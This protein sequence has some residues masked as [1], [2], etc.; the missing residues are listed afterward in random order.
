MKN[1]IWFLL[2]TLV[3]TSLA[4]SVTLPF[5]LTNGNIGETETLEISETYDGNDTVRLTIEM[6]AGDIDIVGGAAGIVEGTVRYNVDEWK[7]E[8]VWDGNRLNITQDLNTLPIQPNMN[9]ENKWDLRLGSQPLQLTLLAGAYDG[10]L[11][12]S[13]IPIAS[14]EIRDGASNAEVNFNSP[15]PI[16]MEEFSYNTGASDVEISGLA[17]ANTASFTFEGGAGAAVLDFSGELQGNML[18]EINAGAGDIRIIVPAGTYCILHNNGELVDVNNDGW[19]ENGDRYT[20][21]GEGPLIEIEAN[22][23]LGSL[24][25]DIR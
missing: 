3:L 1:K 17:N 22:L 13:G 20:S 19:E 14:L 21:P 23:S 25:L 12:L 6:G 9:I 7:P 18:V 10:N 4:C 15:N 2:I 16:R 8:I 5:N 11:D 24:E